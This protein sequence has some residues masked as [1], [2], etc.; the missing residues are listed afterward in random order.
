MGKSNREIEANFLGFDIEAVKNKLREL[1]ATDEGEVLI[2]ERIFDF[3]ERT[4]D[5]GDRF[6]RLRS[7]RGKTTLT[8]KH[9]QQDVVDG[10]EEIEF[11]VTDRELTTL[12]VQRLGLQ[13]SGIVEKK[14][15][16]FRLDTLL[17][18]FDTWPTT[19][20]LLQIEGPSEAEIKAAAESL[21]LNWESAIF[22]G[23]KKILLDHMGLNLDDYTVLT[24][25]KIVNEPRYAGVAV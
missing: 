6:V 23:T 15:H 2:H 4:L 22:A 14:R 24:F 7:M 12:F 9:H 8:Y 5:G 19:E 21:G 3:A 18:D 25:E 16:N 1:G 13:L 20:T 11:G 10:T 17:I